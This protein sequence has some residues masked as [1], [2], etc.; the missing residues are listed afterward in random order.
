M[1]D[2]CANCGNPLD[3]KGV[4]LDFCGP[5][6]QEKWQ[7]QGTEPLPGIAPILPVPR[8]VAVPPVARLKVEVAVES[9][10]QVP[11]QKAPE[12]EVPPDAPRRLAGRN[13]FNRLRMGRRA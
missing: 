3:P 8:P 13:P 9:A 2:T 6:C 12:L 1:T 5:R 11:T 7:E 4:S 10:P